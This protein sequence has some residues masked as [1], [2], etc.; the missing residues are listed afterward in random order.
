MWQIAGRVYS[1]GGAGWQMVGPVRSR[2]HTRALS[3]TCPRMAL[4]ARAT[5][6]RTS[7]MPNGFDMGLIAAEL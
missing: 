1:G 5:C 4:T 7:V 6:L 2:H 3:V